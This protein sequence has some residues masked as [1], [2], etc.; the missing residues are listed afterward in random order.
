MSDD[1][2]TQTTAHPSWW[3]RNFFQ[4][5]VIT[6][7]VMVA[8]LGAAIVIETVTTH[9]RVTWEV[10]LFGAF[11]VSVSMLVAAPALSA[12]SVVMVWH[13]M[14]APLDQLV[15]VDALKE[16]RRCVIGR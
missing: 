3:E 7:S 4:L 16:L 5:F 10:A 13:L 6:V 12:L 14:T 9:H 11:P 15:N 1:N 2:P 8:D